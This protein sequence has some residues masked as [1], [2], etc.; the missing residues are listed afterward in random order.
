M[1][2]PFYI[3]ALTKLPSSKNWSVADAIT[4]RYLDFLYQIG[5]SNILL[6]QKGVSAGATRQFKITLNKRNLALG[7]PIKTS[8]NVD[9]MSFRELLQIEK[10]LL[11]H[12]IMHEGKRPDISYIKGYFVSRS[13]VSDTIDYLLDH[14]ESSL[15]P[16]LWAILALIVMLGGVAF[17]LLPITDFS[18]ICIIS[19]MFCSGIGSAILFDFIN[20]Q[21]LLCLSTDIKDVSSTWEEV[22][23]SNSFADATLLG[24]VAQ[25]IRYKGHIYMRW[26]DLTPREALD[27]CKSL[28]YHSDY[29]LD[30]IVRHHINLKPDV[31]LE[32][33]DDEYEE[34][35]ENT[36]TYNLLVNSEET[37][38]T[39]F[40]DSAI[41]VP[42]KSAIDQE[43]YLV[44]TNNN[45]VNG[46]NRSYTH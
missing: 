6:L 15:Y 27:F 1:T 7:S 24:L 10:Q 16:I 13:Q 41:P 34:G 45:G 36:P 31:D 43:A 42:K 35:D 46:V 30:K 40:L 28:N 26:S 11:Q 32:E 3:K 9:E 21:R 20:S 44:N 12:E 37:V 4:R 18:F 39:S 29:T 38:I 33:D 25:H 8:K 23:E 14:K 5:Q 17:T 2:V 19:A 22:F